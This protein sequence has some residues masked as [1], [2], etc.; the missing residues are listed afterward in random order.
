MPF[1]N[2]L[3]VVSAA[4]RPTLAKNA[5]MGHPQLWWRRRSSFK[6]WA[7]RP[8]TSRKAREVAHP[9]LFRSMLQR[10]TRAILSRN[11]G[12]P[13]SLRIISITAETNAAS[14]TSTRAQTMSQILTV[15]ANSAPWRS[16][17]SVSGLW[18]SL[19]AN[20]W[21]AVVSA[22]VLTIGAVLEYRQQ[23]KLLA[24]LSTKWLLRKAAPFEVCA[25]R[26]LLLH[27]LGPI[28]VVVGIAGEVIFEGRT[29]ILENRQERES[30]VTI[31][32]LKDRTST[33]EAKTA[34]LQRDAAQLI[35]DA[36]DERLAR[37]KIEAS[38]A[39]R[40][41]SAAQ[42]RELCNVLSPYSGTGKLALGFV[43]H[44]SSDREAGNFAIEIAKALRCGN[45]NTDVLQQGSE[46]SV[47]AWSQLPS[48]VIVSS[49]PNSEA[50]RILCGKLIEF[51]F[52]CS[53][54]KP[55]PSRDP[56]YRLYVHVEH[57]PNGPQGEYKLQAEQDA[58][59]K[60][61]QAQTNQTAK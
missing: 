1:P 46:F 48:G 32:S 7:T 23:L 47:N 2:L 9:Q 31:S 22:L 8:A 27:A 21:A 3:P 35:K 11:G 40:E 33:S 30:Q 57:R 59:A 55:V 52:E 6:G 43:S 58:E 60:K 26:K 5:R 37:V 25:L 56:W 14:G 38:V 51:G 39:W 42:E 10:Q 20:Q 50:A 28:L 53:R 19:A 41:L 18:N 45:W 16:L 29:F 12:P 15:A 17:S 36:E 13:A 54:D 4:S 44:E 49:T 24:L 34:Q 61:K